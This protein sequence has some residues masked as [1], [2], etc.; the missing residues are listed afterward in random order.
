MDANTIG[1]VLALL[2]VVM[3]WIAVENR[4]PVLGMGASALWAG[5]LAYVLA[6]TTAGLTWQ[7]ILI[8]AC[9]TFIVTYL[10]MGFLGRRYMPGKEMI[11]EQAEPNE[12]FL[13]KMFNENTGR[14]RRSQHEST[15]D[16]QHRIRSTLRKGRSRVATKR[17]R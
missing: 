6:E 11:E 12:S 3:S 4:Q 9:I 13:F 10:F 16:Y 17:R 15:E 7:V 5:M 14:R 1:L 8:L 2:T